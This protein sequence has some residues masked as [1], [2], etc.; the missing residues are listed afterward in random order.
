MFFGLDRLLKGRKIYAWSGGAMALCEQVLLYHD[1]TPYGIGT[2]EIFDRGLGL[3][4]NTFLLAHA[5]QRLDLSNTDAIAILKARL[6]P[7]RAICIENGAILEGE[8]LE[9]TG[10]SGSAFELGGG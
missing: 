8:H 1:Y 4:P 10:K 3:I 2:A 6:A 9:N 7:S 5:R